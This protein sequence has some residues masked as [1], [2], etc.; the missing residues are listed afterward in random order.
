MLPTGTQTI[1]M[2][3]NGNA[4][5]VTSNTSVSVSIVT[6]IFVMNATA[7]N[8][9]DASNTSVINIPGVVFVD[10]SSSSA[11]RARDSASITGGAIQVVGGVKKAG[12]ATLNPPPVTGVS[13]VADP[14]ASLA[15]PTSGSNKGSI[16]ISGTT[17][18]TIDPGIY[19]SIS[20][21]GHA[22]LIL[23]PGIYAI[24]GGGLRIS[25]SGTVKGTG[26]LIYN[27][28]SNYPGSGGSF[29]SINLSNSAML[30]I[31]AATTGT[32]AGVAVFQSR[33]NMQALSVSNKAVINLQ[34]GLLYAIKATL[35]VGTN[36]AVRRAP[37]IVDQLRLNGSG[38][39]KNTDSGAP[40][41]N[42]GQA[43]RAQTESLA[44]AI[45]AAN[46]SLLSRDM[47]N[48]PAFRVGGLPASTLAVSVSSSSETGRWAG[49]IERLQRTRVAAEMPPLI[50]LNCGSL[51][52]SALADWPFVVA[53]PHGYASTTAQEPGDLQYVP[54][55]TFLMDP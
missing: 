30:N 6:S 23:N 21:S 5:F 47:T 11:L 19:S 3:Y 38:V 26:V 36:A 4:N 29:G 55:L 20:V 15:A 9:L 17:T 16:S 50:S 7:D 28:G 34:G 31:S 51:T 44:S 41:A 33:D 25:D 8:A 49:P 48:G 14:W 1:K 10:S 27:A 2:T 24:A 42:E 52:S 22:T 12:G 37:L 53:S 54:A 13:A 45:S 46:S 18:K 35:T 32:Y 40:S 43:R 39:I